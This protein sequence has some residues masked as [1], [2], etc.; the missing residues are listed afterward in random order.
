MLIAHIG[1]QSIAASTTRELDWGL[2]E[3]QAIM[4]YAAELGLAARSSGSVSVWWAGIAADPEFVG[5]EFDTTGWSLQSPILVSAFVARNVVTAVGLDNAVARAVS[6]YPEGYLTTRNLVLALLST[7]GNEPIEFSA[8]VHY[9]RAEL[10]DDEQLALIA[11]RN[12]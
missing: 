4:I 10:T 5:V 12:R 7:I 1:E 2:S 8:E 6:Q 11:V 3:R 9:K